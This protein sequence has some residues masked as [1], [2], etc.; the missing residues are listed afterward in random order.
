MRV[1]VVS[2]WPPWPLTDGAR[3]VL[4]H[5]LRQLADDHDITVLA[6]ARP[7]GSALPSCTVSP[8]SLPRVQW[9]GPAG[10]GAHEY[11]RRRWQSFRTL[12]PGDVHRVEVP[13]LLDALTV[14]LRHRPDV[15]HLHGWGTA[16]LWARVG[17]RPTLHVAVDSWSASLRSHQALPG[18][19]RLLEA[20]EGRRVRRHEHRHYPRCGAV[21]VVTRRD[22]ARV[23]A[24]A[25]AARVEVVPNGVE[26]A[27]G[28]S[29]PAE[30]PVLGFHGALCTV[31]NSSAA[32]SL[33]GEVLPAVRVRCPDA[34]VLLI[35]RDP[36]PRVRALAGPAVEVT[37][38]VPDVGP[39]LA[40][41]AVYVA[42]LPAAAGM[43]NKVLEAMAAGLPV[44]ATPEAIEGIGEG[45]GIR[46]GRDPA[47][48]A[49]LAADLLGDAEAR[50]RLG[51]SGRRR[52]ERDFTWAASARA[53][54][55]LWDELAGS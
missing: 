25:P 53:V 38:E 23:R 49:G 41:V 36:P 2:A 17:D 33:V 52:V 46:V 28:V 8:G 40:R 12:E 7:P 4:H 24:V 21:V 32:R 55:R 35:G 5:H 34:R 51:A 18:W 31:A 14:E 3:L 1:L 43:K 45:P 50:R 9:F 29:G 42:P 22:A 20:G 30:A 13:G 47:E 19:R 15:V 6:S 48:L 16:Q 10:E 54:E 26:P 44:V 27:S 11:A 37:G 39:H